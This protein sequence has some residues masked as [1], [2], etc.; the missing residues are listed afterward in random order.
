[1][2]CVDPD[3]GKRNGVGLVFKRDGTLFIG[4]FEKGS[5]QGLGVSLDSKLNSQIGWFQQGRI[6]GFG[7]C[8]LDGDRYSGFLES[9]LYSG[10]GTYFRESESTWTTSQFTQGEVCRLLFKESGKVDK[11]ISLLGNRGEYCAPNL[12]E[13][14]QIITLESEFMTHPVIEDQRSSIDLSH[15][16][17]AIILLQAVSDRCRTRAGSFASE[18]SLIINR[19]SGSSWD[20]DAGSKNN[21][22][23]SP[24]GVELPA[25][26]SQTKRDWLTHSNLTFQERTPEPE[27]LGDEQTKPI[28][29][30]NNHRNDERLHISLKKYPIAAP[31]TRLLDKKGRLTASEDKQTPPTSAHTD[32]AKQPLRKGVILTVTALLSRTEPTQRSDQDG[33]VSFKPAVRLLCGRSRLPAE[34]EE[35][36][37]PST[38]D[39]T[40]FSQLFAQEHTVKTV[41]DVAGPGPL[42]LQ[43][44]EES[45]H[46]FHAFKMR[47]PK[48]VSISDL[49]DQ[50]ADEAVSARMSVFRVVRNSHVDDDRLPTD[51]EQSQTEYAS[52]PGPPA[53]PVE[54]SHT[55]NKRGSVDGLDIGIHTLRLTINKQAEENVL[56]AEPTRSPFLQ[57]HR[58]EPRHHEPEDV[59]QEESPRSEHVETNLGSAMVIPPNLRKFSDWTGYEYSGLEDFKKPRSL[60]HMNEASVEQVREIETLMTL[61]QDTHVSKKT[62]V[63][64]LQTECLLSPL[65]EFQLH[66]PLK[67]QQKNLKI[68]PPVELPQDF[69]KLNWGSQENMGS[70]EKVYTKPRLLSFQNYVGGHDE[71]LVDFLEQQRQQG[72]LAVGSSKKNQPDVQRSPKPV[73][74][75]IEVLNLT[76]SLVIT[77]HHMDHRAARHTPADR[78]EFNADQWLRWIEYQKTHTARRELQQFDSADSNYNSDY[79]YQKCPELFA[80]PEL[81]RR[82]SNSIKKPGKHLPTLDLSKLP[83]NQ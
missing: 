49:S 64:R 34:L 26:K 37:E 19:K 58:V 31:T 8:Y 62:E 43:K 2:G 24:L 12:S 6:N 39:V 27:A 14:V 18:R 52:V 17:T 81:P 82:K 77:D 71:E 53:F 76:P 35:T 47:H 51:R 66:R 45:A 32:T 11:D 72:S 40:N 57:S 22:P 78:Q 1:M 68:P 30:H 33:T 13:S 50:A 44:N 73:P 28:E 5:M 75:E 74:S 69:R 70:P 7:N 61:P 80:T 48:P 25:H 59:C 56:T 15:N 54:S 79:F 21:Q 29:S 42:Q 46:L 4:V 36:D 16:Q 55:K 3:S 63:H 67:E 23:D 65:E 9:G 38:R 20:R 10:P 83:S 41:S 60:A